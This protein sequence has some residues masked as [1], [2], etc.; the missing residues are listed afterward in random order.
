M[1][2]AAMLNPLNWKHEDRVRLLFAAGLGALVGFATDYFPG[3]LWFNILCALV[4][5][6]LVAGAYYCYRAFW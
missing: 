4:G 6:V 1:P 2:D 3:D 5:A